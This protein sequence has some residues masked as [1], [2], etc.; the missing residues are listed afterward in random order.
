MYA[1]ASVECIEGVSTICWDTGPY[2][3]ITTYT[4]QV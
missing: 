4:I 2:Y 1:E 3:D